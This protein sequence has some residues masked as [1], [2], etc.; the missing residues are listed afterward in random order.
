[1]VPGQHLVGELFT[2]IK[3]QIL[4]TEKQLSIRER[5]HLVLG[6]ALTQHSPY[7]N[8]GVDRDL[9]PAL[10]LAIETTVKSKGIFP[11]IPRD[12]FLGMKHNRLLPGN[13]AQ[14]LPG[15]VEPENQM[16]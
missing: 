1:M 2:A 8:Y 15:Y 4:V 10:S 6:R 7:R 5:G 9:R 11:G 14:W 13:P 16:S 12:H 3:A